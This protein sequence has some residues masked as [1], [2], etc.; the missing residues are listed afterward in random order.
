MR[1]PFICGIGLILAGTAT[2]GTIP[3]L[4][5]PEGTLSVIPSGGANVSNVTCGVMA[6]SEQCTFTITSPAMTAS[7]GTS[8]VVFYLLEQAGSTVVSDR[9]LN[10]SLVNVPPP[11]Y[12]IWQFDSDLDGGPPLPP[13]PAAPSAVED[14]TAQTVET[15]TYF[16]AIVTLI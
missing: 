13:N 8:S 9:V 3:V 1:L 10:T 14:G 15:F 12:T 16:Y 4:D 11:P 5:S 7:I 2:A 6:G